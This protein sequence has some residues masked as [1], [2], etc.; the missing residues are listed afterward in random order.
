MTSHGQFLCCIIHV[1]SPHNKRIAIDDIRIRQM[2]VLVRRCL[3]VTEA[4]SVGNNAVSVAI[5]RE[6]LSVATR[7]VLSVAAR[8]VVV[9]VSTRRD[10][11]PVAT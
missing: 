8:R 3:V 4:M 11:V 6:V 1:L 7:D 10:V 9:P 2:N 5:Q